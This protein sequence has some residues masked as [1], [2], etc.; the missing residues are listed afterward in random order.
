MA[1]HK[2][3]DFTK[4]DGNDQNCIFYCINIDRKGMFFNFD[5]NF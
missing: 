3:G 5:S 1:L 4:I 2:N